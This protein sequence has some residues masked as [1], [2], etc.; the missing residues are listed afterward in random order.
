MTA[1]SAVLANSAIHTA[2]VVS[3]STAHSSREMPS[4]KPR[5]KTATLTR[6]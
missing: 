5:A 6:A 1:S 4:Q 3:T 2:V